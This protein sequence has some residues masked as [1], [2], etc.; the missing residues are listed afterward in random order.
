MS[1]PLRIDR[2]AEEEL[3]AAVV[4]YEQR[5]EGLGADFTNAVFETLG[6]I[7]DFPNLGSPFPGVP[8]SLGALRRPVRRF[9]YQVVYLELA[10]ELQVVAIAHVR[11][12]PGYWRVRLDA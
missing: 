8:R 12:R 6:Q 4:W 9:P 10:D 1:R 3:S 7:R 11:R 2:E 5:R